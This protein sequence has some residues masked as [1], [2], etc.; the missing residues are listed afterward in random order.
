[1]Q[2]TS[3]S[4]PAQTASVDLE[5][6]NPSSETP[7]PPSF[8]AACAALAAGL[9][10]FGSAACFAKAF[11][12]FGDKTPCDAGTQASGFPCAN[13]EP[14]FGFIAGGVLLAFGALVSGCGALNLGR[15]K[16]FSEGGTGRTGAHRQAHHTSMG[17]WNIAT[18]GASA[19]AFGHSSTSGGL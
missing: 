1:M 5:R 16:P 17:G 12:A 9:L 10:A 2:N 4:R 14:S 19:G 18:H 7:K 11:H 3:I 8:G 6:N 13:D 15:G